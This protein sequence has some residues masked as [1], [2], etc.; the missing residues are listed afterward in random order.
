MEIL[1]AIIEHF[2]GE[3]KTAGGGISKMF[4]FSRRHAKNRRGNSSP[5][6]AVKKF[7]SSL[8]KFSKLQRSSENLWIEQ[9]Q[10]TLPGFPAHTLPS[11]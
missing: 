1:C 5:V 2:N 8:S 6:Q 10:E 3:V 11:R 9:V 7:F 4:I